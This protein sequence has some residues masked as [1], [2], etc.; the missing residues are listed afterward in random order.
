M[1]VQQERERRSRIWNLV[2]VDDC[3]DLQPSKLRELQIYGGASGIWIDKKITAAVSG[4]DQGVAVSVLHTGRHYPDDLSEDGML[5]HYPRTQ[6]PSIRDQSEIAATKN[7]KKLNL[8]IFVILPGRKTTSRSLKIGWME[9]WDDDEEIFLIMFGDKP[10]TYF[11]PENLEA[12]FFLKQRGKKHRTSKTKVRPHQ[13]HFRHHVMSKYGYKCAVCEINHKA[14]I[15][16][17]HIC[18]VDDNGSDD[19]RNGIPLCGTHHLAF[20]EPDPLFCFNPE[21]KKILMKPGITRSSISITE[22][23][24][25]TK[26]GR[27]PHV[28]ALAWKEKRTKKTWKK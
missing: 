17:A 19:W 9:A 22:S 1:P 11:E 8:P 13:Q 16:A 25:S 5:Y 4:E 2:R 20:D 27:L 3:E 12:Q 21:D 23:S 26:N 28:E 7:A 6:R 18:G 15:H 10:T 24:L 14:L